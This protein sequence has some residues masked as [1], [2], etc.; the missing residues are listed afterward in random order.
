VRWYLDPANH[1][2]AMEIC[3]PDHPGSR[4]S[5]FGW[6]FSTGKDNYRETRT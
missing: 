1:K 4:L 5:G 3:A 6:V 2:E